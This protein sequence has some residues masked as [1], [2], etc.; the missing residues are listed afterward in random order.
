MGM[1]STTIKHVNK[2]SGKLGVIG[3]EWDI[4]G[5][6]WGQIWKANEIYESSLLQVI[7]LERRERE[8]SHATRERDR[9]RE[10]DG[11]GSEG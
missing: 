11:V 10:R 3:W 7:T 9:E 2:G 5:N 8:C 4:G 1:L 6:G